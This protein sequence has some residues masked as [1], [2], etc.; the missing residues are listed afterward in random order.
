[1]NKLRIILLLVLAVTVLLPAQ[2]K[3]KI[4][5]KIRFNDLYGEVT[6]RPND[7]DDDAYEFAELDTVIY[8]DDRIRTEEDSGAI[9][10]LEDMSTYVIKPESTLIIH[11]EDG[12]V[13]K[14]EMLAG[15]LWKNVKKM[16]EGKSLEVEMS[17]IVMSINGTIFRAFQSKDGLSWNPGNRS[18]QCKPER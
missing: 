3:D 13:S 5:S 7:E 2:A 17:Q 12:T 10:G 16:A 14:I 15:S 4:D 1:M 18:S 8:E 11:T 9:L 6:I